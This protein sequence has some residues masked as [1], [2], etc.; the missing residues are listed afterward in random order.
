V[1]FPAPDQ[2]VDKIF[3]SSIFTHMFPADVMHYLAEMNRVL[4]P[5]AAV[6]TTMFPLNDMSLES[7]AAKKAL[8]SFHHSLP[9]CPQCR[10]EY[11][12]SL[13]G[14]IAYLEGTY[15]QM[16]HANG[17]ELEKPIEYG[18]WS[19]TGARGSDGQDYVIFGKA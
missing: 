17:T 16:L 15:L 5:G 8:F 10:F 13:E 9:E 14:A 7:I 19:G 18:Q 1:V 2:S 6:L 3:L 12:D 11:S 4:K